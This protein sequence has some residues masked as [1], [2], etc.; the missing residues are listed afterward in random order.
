MQNLFLD[1]KIE[2]AIELLKKNE[3]EEGY[4]LAFSG[5]KDSIT[6]Y[7]LAK[8]SGVKFEAHFHV[9][10]VDPPE[11]LRFIKQNY[12]DVIWDYPKI[13]MLKLIEKHRMLPL[14]QIRFCCT[15]LKELHGAGRTVI[16]GVRATESPRRAKRNKIERDEHRNKTFIH[17][18]FDWTD[19]EV[20]EFI[21]KQKLNYCKLYDEGYH[22]IGCIGCPMKNEKEKRKDFE[23]YPYLEVAYKNALKKAFEGRPDKNFGTNVDEYFEWWLSGVSIKKYFKKKKKE[24][25]GKDGLERTNA[26]RTSIL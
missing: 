12:P 5:G 25:G 8:L 24:S 9:T 11:L 16:D 23:R 22:R 2:K 6:I 17:V 13:N 10:T 21:R 7:Q 4:F 19:E 15:H 1:E 18:I 3:P 20:W 14:R 26:E